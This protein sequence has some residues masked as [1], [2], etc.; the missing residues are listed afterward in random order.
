M[1][2]GFNVL[3]NIKKSIKQKALFIQKPSQ[4][5]NVSFSEMMF[6]GENA[7]NSIDS[8]LWSKISRENPDYKK[9][10]DLYDA[11]ITL[12]EEAF[13]GVF[14]AQ[15][16]DQEGQTKSKFKIYYQR[17][18]E[19]VKKINDIPANNLL[20][21]ES[22]KSLISYFNPENLQK[23]TAI[24]KAIEENSGIKLATAN[25]IDFVKAFVE[26]FKIEDKEIIFDASNMF[27][28]SSLKKC[29]E[30]YVDEGSIYEVKETVEEKIDEL[31]KIKKALSKFNNVQ[32]YIDGTRCD[33][34]K[35]NNK[36]FGKIAEM[37]LNNLSEFA[38]ELLAELDGIV[39]TEGSGVTFF[40]D[41]IDEFD[42]SSTAAK[43]KKFS[44]AEEEAEVKTTVAEKKQIDNEKIDSLIEGKFKNIIGLSTVKD[45]L[46]D[47]I[48]LCNKLKAVNKF[49]MAHNHM[50][51]VGKP[52]TGK[53][54]VA[55][56][57]AE[58]LYD[59]GF[60]S[61]KKLTEVGGISLQGEYLG[62]TGPKVQK[63]IDESRGG[64]LFIDEAYQIID[65]DRDDDTYGKEA[66]STLIKNMEDKDDLMIIFAGYEKPTKQMIEK[67]PGLQ[68]RITNTIKFEDYSED[69]LIKIAEVQA[70]EKCFKLDES[71]KNALRDYLI[72]KKKTSNF[73]NGRCVRNI[74]ESAEKFQ[75]RRAG[76]DDFNITE[77]DVVLA[78]AKQKEIEKE[79]EAEEENAINEEAKK[80]ADKYLIAMKAEKL[81]RQQMF[82]KE[83]NNK[84]KSHKLGFGMTN[85]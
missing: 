37:P 11:L 41:L 35:I 17:Y 39:Q 57:V 42:N 82:E 74:V 20:V 68:S 9:L 16:D 54:T 38:N 84:N 56:I 25:Y 69:E 45:E 5:S 79:A 53:T 52:G 14:L 55:R 23:I 8:L 63:I 77:A 32:L 1:N 27:G 26:Y 29:F 50:C 7:M 78:I 83:E 19:L 58:V 3:G 40:D 72:E 59:A 75:T 85:D 21:D 31:K 10:Y 44:D 2:S 22:G 15:E 4:E 13:Q 28:E 65:T 36:F 81:A 71:S 49:T 33:F 18:E 76:M 67:N 12:E 46:K 47:M 80:R 62:Q 48:K 70:K 61:S 34:K 64:V 24:C 43:V 73:A 30:T 6:C 60:L 66:I 51:F